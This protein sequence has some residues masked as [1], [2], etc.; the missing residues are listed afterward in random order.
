MRTIRKIVKV[1]LASPGDLK[2]ERI[3][4]HDAV[5]E[6]NRLHGE[7]WGYHVE[8]VG[9]E[10]VV[11]Q[12]QRPQAAINRDLD[13]CELF[14]G[15]LWERWGTPPDIN[16]PYTSGF[17]EE[18][19]RSVANQVK[20]EKPEISLL[21]K[22]I[23]SGRLKDPGEQLKKV[24]AFKERLIGEKKI[25]FEIFADIGTLG[26]KVR[27]IIVNYVYGLIAE[28]ADERSRK[29]QESPPDSA[30]PENAIAGA[31]TPVTG[32]FFSKQGATFVQTLLNKSAHADDETKL[33]SV[34][35]AR[36][37][38]LAAVLGVH[39]NDTNNLGVHDANLL[40]A[41][42]SELD[43]GRIETRGLFSAGLCNLT[44]ENTP[45]WHWLTKIGRPVPNALSFYLVAGSDELMFGAI[46]AMTL[47]KQPLSTEMG[48][49]RQQFVSAWLQS[50]TPNVRVA[51]LE[52]LAACGLPEDLPSVR[53]EFDRANYQ[54]KGPALDALLRITSRESRQ[55]AITLLY[56][57]QPES[58][59]MI[60]IAHDRV[61]QLLQLHMSP[62]LLSHVI[63][64]VADRAFSQLP[65]KLIFQFLTE[66][67]IELAADAGDPTF[68]VAT[69]E[70]EN[71]GDMN[72]NDGV[73]ERIEVL[74]HN[75]A[76]LGV[77]HPIASSVSPLVRC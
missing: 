11:S 3:A 16:G 52:Y 68:V 50:D 5:V 43:L 77:Y 57:L 28:E 20:T 56:D 22:D 19:E 54:T 44:S 18:F 40:F 74:K 21:F 64:H 35:V 12:S 42:S 58:V 27:A 55:Q 4:A 25:Y 59:D 63:V 66:A 65:N 7:Q 24:I 70:Y 26:Q 69:E 14:I 2:D 67:T 37:R 71:V 23:D 36:F 46:K 17:E 76:Q 75:A 61:P 72:R 8:L 47:L 15:M 29:T 30:T 41:H 34:E 48:L 10:D 13:Q 62:S 51:G 73:S 33:T 60:S 6:L 9:W 1:F 53:E 45:I 31:P 39:G 38:L 32:R 49:Q